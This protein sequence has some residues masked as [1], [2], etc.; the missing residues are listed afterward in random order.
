MPFPRGGGGGGR[1]PLGDDRYRHSGSKPGSTDGPPPLLDFGN[2][3]SGLT[4]NV[5]NNSLPSLLSVQVENSGNVY[6]SFP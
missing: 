5:N 3:K 6:L 4:A 2:D 1:D